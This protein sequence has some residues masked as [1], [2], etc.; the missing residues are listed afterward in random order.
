M[1]K[2]ISTFICCAMVAAALAVPMSITANDIHNYAVNSGFETG[3]IAPWDGYVKIESAERHTG[4]YSARIWNREN[5]WDRAFQKITIP[6][7]TELL[8]SVWV[9]LA[10]GTPETVFTL[11]GLL[12]EADGTTE[13][14]Y[15]SI[16]SA[17]VTDEEWTCVSGTFTQHG[18]AGEN[19]IVSIYVTDRTLSN[20]YMD[21]FT[22]MPV[23]VVSTAIDGA[24]SFLAPSIG[25][26]VTKQ[27]RVN[28]KDQS[29]NM[30]S[31][32]ETTWSVCDNATGMDISGI[33]IDMF[34][35]LTVLDTAEPCIMKLA[36]E[37]TYQGTG[38]T[39]EKIVVLNPY[40]DELPYLE[41][42]LSELSSIVITEE[43]LNA[44]TKSLGEL[45]SYLSNGAA[46]TWRSCAPNI[47]SDDG[48]VYPLPTQD[49]DVRL[50]AAVSYG[51]AWVEKNYDLTVRSGSKSEAVCDYS[52]YSGT[53][54]PD[55]VFVGDIDVNC[56]VFAQ[57]EEREAVLVLA[58]YDGERL[59]DVQIAV[60]SIP[61][62][63]AKNITCSIYRPNDNLQLKIFLLNNLSEVLPLDSAKTFA[64]PYYVAKNGND[65]NIGT[66]EHPFA[67]IGKAAEIMQAGDVCVVREGVY[68]ETVTPGGTGTADAPITFMAYPG[69]KVVISGADELDLDWQAESDGTYC[70]SY[71]KTATQ[72]FVDGKQ[73]NIA[74]W[75]NV[76]AD[77]LLNAANY[78]HAIDGS[79][80]YIKVNGLPSGDWNGAIAHMWTGAAWY[81]YEKTVTYDGL[82]NQL[83]FDVPFTPANNGY[84]DFDYRK[85]KAG[86]LF[87]LYGVRAALDLPT[88]WL[89]DGNTRAL[90]LGQ[91]P[92][93]KVIEVKARD[94]GFQISNKSYINI[95][96]FSF[97]ANAID[98]TGAVNSVIDDCSFKYI[99]DTEQKSILISG[100]DNTIKNSSIAYALG[101]GVFLQ[102]NNNTVQNCTIHDVNTYGDYFGAVRAIG[103]GHKILNNT[104]YNS[105]RFL[106]Y[107][108][109]STNLLIQYNE[110]YNGGILTE[111]LG[112]T[113]AWGAN[114]NTAEIS[115]NWI[116]DMGRHRGIYLDNFCSNYSVHHNLIYNVG[117]GIT[118]N[119]DSLNNKVY[120]NTIK[121]ITSASFDT[122]AYTGYVEDQRG[123][124]IINNITEGLVRVAESEEYAPKMSNNCRSMLD[125]QFLPIAGSP[126]IDGG[127][128]IPGITDDYIGTAPDIGAYEVGGKYWVA[129]ARWNV[130]D[131]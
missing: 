23:T 68:R 9:K 82:T 106:V 4:S 113:Y 76:Q 89:Q 107:H 54:K 34:G 6:N 28:A 86:N 108:T 88:E 62:D 30:I 110:M 75:P 101:N 69:E 22:V 39:A 20:F 103:D 13:A 130:T 18:T 97:F 85:P 24:D 64:L 37:I 118:L 91:D 11:T 90:S 115:Y 48:T 21:D 61:K 112:A 124:E 93:G 52:L 36:A 51:E 8:Y 47:V 45:P 72:L 57:D 5:V 120:N 104:M 19:S 111:D 80:G 59:T 55:G 125:E 29:G 17:M 127:I 44:I 15:Q 10:A 65:N 84:D 46:V 77:N 96:G 63:T 114:D 53:Q 60:E 66:A 78:A 26:T 71:D 105:G 121:N 35:E 100:S 122:Y 83:N 79:Y 87:Y 128:I 67:T 16:A 25:K 74:R 7:N 27:Y 32:A 50:I 38:N 1:K 49:V 95:K 117:H 3:A 92:T 12:Y 31:G 116:H 131:K 126:A 99:G 43:P 70:A 81:A 123:T 94:W 14:A 2:M 102:G 40:A 41:E 73:M 58:V 129:G 109:Y 98:A 33:S 42:G 56:Y 119:S